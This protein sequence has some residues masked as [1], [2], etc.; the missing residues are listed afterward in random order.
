MMRFME[1]ALRVRALVAADAPIVTQFVAELL[2]EI[3]ARAGA[4]IAYDAERGQMQASQFL[5]TGQAMGYLAEEGAPAGLLLLYEGHALYA[6]GAFGILS[7]LYVRPP[8]RGRGVGRQLIAAARVLG[9]ALQWRHLEVTTPPLP[10]FQDTLCF[11]ESLG[12]SVSGG[13]KLRTAL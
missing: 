11:Y 13:R 3:A 1:E 4:R 5:N 8:Y 2:E 12:F 10:A 6:G 7:E 9:A